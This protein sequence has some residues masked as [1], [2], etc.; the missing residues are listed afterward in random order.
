[1][2]ASEFNTEFAKLVDR[3]MSEGIVPRKMS[4]IELVG[5]IDCVKC[6]LQRNFQ[7]IARQAREKQQPTIFLPKRC[8]GV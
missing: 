2:N 6:D 7:D 8:P 4:P 3:A 5:I 1:M